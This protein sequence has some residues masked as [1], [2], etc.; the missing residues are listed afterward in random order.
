MG[1]V[2]EGVEVAAFAD[3][4][5]LAAGQEGLIRARVS[6][7]IVGRYIGKD[8]GDGSSL[9]D[10]WFPTGDI[11]RV[12]DDGYLTILGRS[13]VVINYGGNKL[14]P[15]FLEQALLWIDGVSAVAVVGVE[16][17]DGF[18]RICAAI[19]CSIAR[20]RAGRR[21]LAS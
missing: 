21:E 14:H 8:V 20:N 5:G 16:A 19:V 10:G 2:I 7:E 12:S 13:S 11:G 6:P 17:A 9:V 15:G 1:K 3:D 18:P 4:N